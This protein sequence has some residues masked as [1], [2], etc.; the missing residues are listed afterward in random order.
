MISVAVF[1]VIVGFYFWYGESDTSVK[2][3]GIAMLAYIA[4][5]ILYLFV[6]PF[7]LGTSSQMGQLY[8]FVPL[9][10]FGAIL[11][12]HF[13]TQSPETV[14]RTIGWIGLVTVA[15]ILVCFKLFVW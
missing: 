14:T 2:E 12:P 9:L 7:P 10:S 15:L 6:P 3:A 4:Y 11:F 13:N 8:G 5:T 1:C